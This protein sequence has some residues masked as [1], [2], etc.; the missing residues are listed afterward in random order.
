VAT[1]DELAAMAQNARMY[2]AAAG[3]TDTIH[4]GADA[5]SQLIALGRGGPGVPVGGTAGGPRSLITTPTF[6]DELRSMAKRGLYP[7]GGAAL[8]AGAAAGGAKLAMD[9]L[10][11]PRQPQA[12][13]DATMQTGGAADLANESRPV[14]VVTPTAD[15]STVAADTANPAAEA[16]WTSKFKRNYLAREARLHP[17]VDDLPGPK[18]QTVQALMKAGI[19]QQRANEIVRGN[20]SISPQEMKLLRSVR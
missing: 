8:A 14:P 16:E 11:T 6:A 13:A 1:P 4:A 7:L 19:P 17:S 9:A 15:P 12:R 18:Q 10:G 3:R 5:G 20:Y 2:A